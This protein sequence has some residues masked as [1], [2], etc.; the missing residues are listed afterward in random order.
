VCN[1][2]MK[3]PI[4][5]MPCLH[6]G[7][8]QCLETYSLRALQSNLDGTFPRHFSQ[9]DPKLSFEIKKIFRFSIG[10]SRE[11]KCPKCHGPFEVPRR[12]IEDLPTNHFTVSA[13]SSVN[14]SAKIDP[15]NVKCE[16]CE[17]NEATVKC[18]N[19]TQFFCDTCQKIHQKLKVSAHHQ[20]ISIGEAL[21]GGSSSS[22]TRILHCQKHPHLEVNSYCKTDQTAVC[23]QC[24]VDSH[25]G[26]DV[27]NLTNLSQGFKDT[28]STLVNKVCLPLLFFFF[29]FFLFFSFLFFFFSD[30]NPRC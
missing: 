25:M 16:L 20:Y 22:A 23:P 26:H 18:S 7:C 3:E 15:N 6:S 11:I 17:E 8:L 12:G 19:C 27:G 10:S 13:V 1:E 29:L 4:R 14:A 9:Y 28:I 2:M 21:Q 24:V 30:S 5:T